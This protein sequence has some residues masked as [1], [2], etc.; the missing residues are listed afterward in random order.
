MKNKINR[1]PRSLRD[2]MI[3]R[4]SVEQTLKVV[5]PIGSTFVTLEYQ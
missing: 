5:Q 4:I 2:V 3:I 1:L